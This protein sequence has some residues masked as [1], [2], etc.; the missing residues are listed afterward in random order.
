MGVILFLFVW[1]IAECAVF[2]L[3]EEAE[4]SGRT[5]LLS[6]ITDSSEDI[7]IATAPLPGR[8]RFLDRRYVE[9]ILKRKGMDVELKGAERVKVVRGYQVITKDELISL[10]KKRILEELRGEKIEL[11]AERAS[12]VV[13]PKG[14]LSFKIMP[15]FRKQRAFCDINIVIDGEEYRRVRL[16]FSVRRFERVVVARRR[17][18]PCSLIALGDL[19]LAEREV[20]GLSSWFV[21]PKELVG[22]EVRCTIPAGEVIE[23]R[24]VTE[25]AIICFGDVVTIVKRGERFVV[26]ALG[27]ALQRGFL[28]ERIRVRNISSK[29]MVEAYV[30]DAET[31]EVK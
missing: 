27:K 3:K 19:T 16:S 25:P 11:V 9:L 31:V 18:S 30:I 12:D 29:R 6:E 10:C 22:K 8:C 17:L 7:E 20:T 15:S 28:G 14:E 26:K 23:G 2:T 5:I 4:V 1:Q 21:S 13:L 24:A